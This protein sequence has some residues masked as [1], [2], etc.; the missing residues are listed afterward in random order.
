MAFSYQGV[1]QWRQ[2]LD[3]LDPNHFLSPRPCANLHMQ[4]IGGCGGPG[5]FANCWAQAKTCACTVHE[6]HILKHVYIKLVEFW[7][8]GDWKEWMTMLFRDLC[9]TAYGLSGM[10]GLLAPR[11]GSGQFF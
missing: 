6:A 7:I 2:C 3:I 1:A 5:V 10:T 8:D 9:R 4:E 11:L